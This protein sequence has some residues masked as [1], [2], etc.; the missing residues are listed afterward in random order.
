MEDTGADPIEAYKALYFTPPAEG[1]PKRHEDILFNEHV[2]KSV[3]HEQL[4]RWF[5]HFP[6]ENFYITTLEDFSSDNAGQ[7]AEI[8]AHIGLSAAEVEALR[9]TIRAAV[10]QRWNVTDKQGGKGQGGG[11]KEEVDPEIV[12]EL[13]RFF[14]PHNELLY[15]L[16]GR[17]LWV[18]PPA[19]E[20]HTSF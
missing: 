11:G 6:R 12:E 3:Y 16:L 13:R 19:P 15:R 7:V 10:Q 4:R 17:R 8:L 9:P 5:A 20:S 14:E 1:E 18:A 2:G